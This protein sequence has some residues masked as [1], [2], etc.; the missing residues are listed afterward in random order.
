[1][2]HEIWLLIQKH[3]ACRLQSNETSPQ[4]DEQRVKTIVE[5]V[6]KQVL[7]TQGFI[8]G[9]QKFSIK[10]TIMLSVLGDF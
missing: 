7:S 5:N 2:L 9:I 4:T 10:Q 3:R 1:M 8:V 6:T